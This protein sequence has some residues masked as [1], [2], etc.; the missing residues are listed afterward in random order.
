MDASVES[1][2]TMCRAHAGFGTTSIL[3]TT[4]AAAWQD[5]YAAID[6]VRLAHPDSTGAKIL[7]VHLEG[8]YFSQTEKG[9]QSADFIKDPIPEEYMAALDY[10]DGIKIMGVAPELPGA[11]ALGRELRRR[12]ILAS[13]AH[14]NA[15]YEEVLLAVENGFAGVVE[16]GYL[17]DELSVQVI[18]DG[19][20]LPASLLKLIYKVKGADR[21]ALI[22]D[23][24]SYAAMPSLQENMLYTQKNGVPVILED[25]VMKLPDRSSFAGSVATTRDLVKNMVELAEVPLCQAVKMATHIGLDAD[26]VVFDSEFSVQLTM[27]AGKIV[28][29]NASG[30][31]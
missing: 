12:G 24:L 7:G 6:A 14:S 1:V 29:Q 28:Y 31:R 17:I 25:G 18:A 2:Q 8:P 27:V 23:A 3:P 5:I 30:F 11:L 26:I 4:V 9:A 16:S 21:I 20:H 19:K 13:I 10:W 22:T 15:N